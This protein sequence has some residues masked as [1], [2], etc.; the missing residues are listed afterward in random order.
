[1][2]KL[3]R[4]SLAIGIWVCIVLVV[5]FWVAAFAAHGWVWAA[6]LVGQAIS[7]VI[8]MYLAHL[9]GKRF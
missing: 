8:G 1:M 7:G 9:Y 4:R 3:K 2:S 5:G 6:L